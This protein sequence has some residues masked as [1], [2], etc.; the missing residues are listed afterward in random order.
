MLIGFIKFHQFTSYHTWSVKLAVAVTVLAYI[1][2][3]T[4]LL[5]WPFRVAALFCLYAAME[6][7][8]ITFINRHEHVDVRSIWQALKYY[9][10]NK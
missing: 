1:L 3:F 8:A 4:G 10:K 7:V 2:L 9:K 5:D 6:E